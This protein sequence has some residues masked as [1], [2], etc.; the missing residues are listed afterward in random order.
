[1]V[2]VL[3]VAPKHTL[4]RDHQFTSA[5]RRELTIPKKKKKKRLNAQP[6][7]KT[8]EKLV[9]IL[10]LCTTSNVKSLLLFCIPLGVIPFDFHQ[11]FDH[12]RHRNPLVRQLIGALQTQLQQ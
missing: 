7:E 3:A 5:H 10:I 11:P 1:M 9:H 4:Y 12:I 8:R 6:R 2:T